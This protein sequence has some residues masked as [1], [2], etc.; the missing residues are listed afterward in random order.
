MSDYF[1]VLFWSLIGGVF[2]MGAGALLLA[3]KKVAGRVG[4]ALM[5]FAAG[6]LLGAAFLDLLPEA[7]EMGSTSSVLRWTVGG[8]LAFFLLEHYLHWF[9]HH[10]DHKES[11][12]PIIP[13]I[14]IGDTVHNAIDGVVIGAAFAANPSL[15]VVTAMAVAT[16]EIPQE[17]GDFSILLNAGVRRRNVLLWNGLSALA[18]VATALLT[19]E[20][21]SSNGIPLPAILGLASGLFIYI[22]TSD[23]LP[24]IHKEAGGKF[25]SSAI[26]LL[27][28]GVLIVGVAVEIL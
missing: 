4:T 24:S 28:L 13:L 19:Y 23:L 8:I 10:D 7:L 25:K 20:I 15:G 1:E 5:P 26:S 6:A 11:K 14:I 17:I 27:I 18:T 12:R 3:N 21:G 9:H 22:A 16:H 2:S